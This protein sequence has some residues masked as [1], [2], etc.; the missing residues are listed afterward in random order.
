[1]G[2]WEVALLNHAAACP[3]P[4]SDLRSAES[5]KQR[6]C[7][8]APARAPLAKGRTGMATGTVKWFNDAK[9]YGFITPGGGGQAV[10]VHHTAIQM[11]GF[12]SLAEGQK[13][14]YEVTAGP[15]GPEA[16]NGPKGHAHSTARLTEPPGRSRPRAVSFLR[17]GF[18][19][20]VRAV[21]DEV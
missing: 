13:V 21:P 2:E 5:W 3:Y 12:R 9:G 6:S 11:E 4:K 15:K 7:T 17:D 14:E 8:K 10:F 18:T 20:S 16:A 19:A 1:M